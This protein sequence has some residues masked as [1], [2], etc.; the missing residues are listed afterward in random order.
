MAF[1]R[2][3]P[4][5]DLPIL[6]P[7]AV[8]ESPNILKKVVTSSR[9]LAEL[10]GIGQ[11]I[12]NQRILIDSILLQEARSSSEIE[13]VITSNDALFKA[14]SAETNKIDPATKEVL[15]YRQAIWDGYKKLEKRSLLTTNLFISL[16]QTVKETQASIRNTPGTKIANTKTGEIIYTPPEGE[17]N[18]RDKLK[19]L[20][21]YIHSSDGIDPLIKMAIIHYQFEAI[22]PFSDGNGRTGRIINILYLVHNNLLELPVLY[23]SKY[24]IEYKTDYYKY[25][26]SVTE[27]DNWEQWII[28]MLDA[29]EKTAI[30]TKDKIYAIRNLLDITLEKAR[31]KLPPHM[32]SKELIELLFYQ[33]YTKVQF[34]VDAGIVKRQTAAEYLQALETNGIL[35]SSKLGR[36]RLYLNLQLY[37]LLSR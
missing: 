15:R 9:A 36:E 22:H 21:E 18:I 12:P 11:S 34:L 10:K 4:Y 24:I 6:P 14:F 37:K 31:K 35:K 2:N 19:N 20:E 17:K 1:N 30:Y 23:L 33:P 32:Y 8:V 5:N 3:T 7:K 25:L 13:N 27:K 16:Y 26:R 29:I 28:F